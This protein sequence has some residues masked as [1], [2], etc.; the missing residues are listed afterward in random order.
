MELRE[1][2]HIPLV[3]GQ[4]SMNHRGKTSQKQNT[5]GQ[6]AKGT[7]KGVPSGPKEGHGFGGGYHPLLPE[8]LV[9]LGL[10]LA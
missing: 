7:S 2:H 1:I 5:E 4:G 3:F 8:G 6:S 9:I 10:S